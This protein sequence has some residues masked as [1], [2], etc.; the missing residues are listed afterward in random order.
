MKTQWY[1]C[2]THTN[3]K[4][5]TYNLYKIQVRFCTSINIFLLNQREIPITIR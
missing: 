5:H 3:I 1:Q 2:I 4:L